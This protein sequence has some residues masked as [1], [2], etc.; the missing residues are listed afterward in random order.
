MSAINNFFT[1]YFV[2]LQN[3]AGI[4]GNN[5]ETMV[6]IVDVLVKPVVKLQDILLS[7]AV[8]LAFLGAPSF[9]TVL[10]GIKAAVLRGASQTFVIASQQA[11]N[12]GRA[13]W[14]AGTDRSQ[15]VQTA[16]LKIKLANISMEM[17]AMMDGGVRLLMTDPVTFANY[18]DNGRYS[19]PN[20]T[21][22]GEGTSLTVPSAGDAVAYA[23]KTYLLSVSLWQNRWYSTF[24]LGPYY[25]QEAV[26]NAYRC[27]FEAS[28][29][30][31]PRNSENH[32]GQ[33]VYWSPFTYR[34]YSF[35]NDGPKEALKPYDMISTILNYGWAPLSVLF[36]GG[37]NCTAEGRAG[38]SAVNFNFDGTL[39][40]ACVSQLPMYTNCGD[41]CPTTQPNGTCFFGDIGTI[42]PGTCNTFEGWQ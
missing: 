9:A 38:S 32:K 23:L 15:D 40:L 16:E 1:T 39:D 26:S 13:L 28:G 5:I 12:V 19:G 17:G 25:T 22:T 34:L 31:I 2:A 29:L 37:F 33:A 41:M 18:A 4:V 10:L 24:V 11:P 20:V 21:D 36:D 30:C 14:P 27:D 3:A 8:G 42:K 35:Q 6:Q 7:L